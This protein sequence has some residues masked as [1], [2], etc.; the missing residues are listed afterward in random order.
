MTRAKRGVGLALFSLTALFAGACGSRG[1]VGKS[2]AA[3]RSGQ[4]A[5]DLK[6]A[7]ARIDDSVI[8]I[9]EFQERINQQSPYIRARYTSLERKKEFLDNLVRFEVLA[10]EA[11]QKGYDKD[12][13]VLRTAKQ[14]MIQKLMKE[15]FDSRVKLDDVRDDECLKFYQAHNEEY[16]KPEEVRASD[17]FVKDKKKADAVAKDVAGK[18]KNG[19]VDAAAFRD[20]VTR[21]GEDEAAKPQGGDLRYFTATGNQ[22]PKELVSAAF[23]LKEV[24]NYTAQPVKAGAG[25]HVLMLTGRRQAL[26]RSFEEVKRQIQSRLFRDRRTQAMDDYVAALKKKANVQIDDKNLA[27]VVVDTSPSPP[28]FGGVPVPPVPGAAAPPAAIAAPRN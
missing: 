23:A 9:G 20:L 25:Y 15:Q 28:T 24:G 1:G 6:E 11:Q 16:N 22:Y 2:G 18:A 27:R 7:V 5:S 26:A 3:A 21:Y 4:S 19:I 14:V 12:P 17:V 10:K 8:T 13:E